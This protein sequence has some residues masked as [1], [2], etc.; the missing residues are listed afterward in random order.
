[1]VMYTYFLQCTLYQIADILTMNSTLKMHPLSYRNNFFCQTV[2]YK[3]TAYACIF[4]I[5]KYSINRTYVTIKNELL[6]YS[7]TSFLLSD[8]YIRCE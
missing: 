6:A 1:M 5:V 8:L 3:F 4:I 2:T 7:Q